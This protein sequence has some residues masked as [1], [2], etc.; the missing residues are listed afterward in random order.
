MICAIGNINMD[1]ICT[2]PHLPTPDEKSNIQSLTIFPGGAAA[3]FA[4]SLARL[5]SN[6]GLFGH[7]GDD[8]EGQAALRILREEKVDISRVRLDTG[9]RT[10]LV[11]ILVGEEG[12]TMKLRYQGANSRLSPQDITTKL[13][14]DVRITYSASVSI[15]I[16]KQVAKVSKKVGAQSAIDIGEELTQQSLDKVRDMICSF[17]IV[18]LNQVVFER[19]FNEPPTLRKV[20]AEIG[21]NLE[22]LNIT[23]GKQGSI[24]AT[25][26]TA[27]KTP[28]FVVE[29]V[30]TTGAGDAFAAGFIHYMHHHFP[31]KEAARRAAACAALQITAPGGRAGLPTSAQVEDFLQTQKSQL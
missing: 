23:L 15:P 2:L 1:W 26:E 17:S 5:G 25:K 16:A 4:T 21:G 8:S 19:I 11:I 28:A 24:T 29:A 6:V 9:L 7:V 14:K 20:Q 13:L 3:N 12:Q 18:F 31:I 27:F 30:D 10:G 22:I